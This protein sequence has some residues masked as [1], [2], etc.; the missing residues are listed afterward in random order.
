MRSENP[1]LNDIEEWRI[2]NSKFDPINSNV[3]RGCFDSV[4]SEWDRSSM[5]EKLEALK[6]L[7]EHEDKNISSLSIG[8]MEHCNNELNKNI[9]PLELIMSMGEIIEY[10]LKNSHAQ[11]AKESLLENS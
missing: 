3:L 1:I 11:K 2:G 9:T 7:V 6:Y 10:L 5:D 8:M 4:S